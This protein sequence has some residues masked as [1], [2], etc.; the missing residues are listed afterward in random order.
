MLPLSF[1]VCRIAWQ[2]DWR[3]LSIFST[4]RWLFSEEDYRVFENGMAASSRDW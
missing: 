3:L 1:E 2:G 4:L